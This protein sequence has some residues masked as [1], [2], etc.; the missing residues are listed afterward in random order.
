[1]KTNVARKNK[2][3]LG[4]E[5]TIHK[6]IYASIFKPWSYI[7]ALILSNIPAKKILSNMK[8]EME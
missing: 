1:M 2:N 4:I 7:V 3:I 5:I 6:K 8:V